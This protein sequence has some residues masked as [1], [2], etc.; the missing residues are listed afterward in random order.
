MSK[1]TLLLVVF[2][3]L[4]APPDAPAQEIAAVRLLAEIDYEAE[5][6]LHIHGSLAESS[7]DVFVGTPGGLYRLPRGF[8]G[9][10]AELHG[11]AGRV[12]NRVYAEGPQIHVLK[13]TMATE[14]RLADPGLLRSDDGGAS[15]RSIDSALIFCFDELCQSM[16]GTELKVD[17]ERLYYAASGNLLASPDGGE[18]W[19]ALAG[20]LEPSFCYDPSFE[21]IGNRVIIGGECPLD[22][23]YVRAGELRAGELAWETEPQ[24]AVT[25][26]L[27]NRNVQFIRQLPGSAAVLA[28]IEGAILRSDDLGASWEFILWYESGG[29]ET[30]KYPYVGSLLAPKGRPRT[31]LA[32][33]FDKA[34]GRAWLAVSSDEGASWRDA[35]ESVWF[36]DQ[37]ESEVVAFLEQDS[38]GRILAGILDTGRTVMRIVELTLDPP[39]RRPARRD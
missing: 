19:V 11:F 16:S 31:L 28:G 26:D 25:P 38:D 17:G 24:G 14:G 18:S 27:E 20:F 23:A 33:G 1:P 37:F 9:E 35:S 21:V 22:I 36:S 39:R 13:E 2:A 3:L 34:A 10:P 6:F 15:F 4:V 30:G 8:D 32:G 29:A 7:R 12:I 5:P